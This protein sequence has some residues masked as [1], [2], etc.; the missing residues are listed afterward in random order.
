MCLNIFLA[1]AKLIRTKV[2]GL[3][4]P[5]AF[6]RCPKI[7]V[8]CHNK[9]GRI[10]EKTQA[11]IKDIQHDIFSNER[12]SMAQQKQ[13]M[14]KFL[15]NI[16]DQTGGEL[17]SIIIFDLKNGLPLYFG[18]YKNPKQQYNLIGNNDIGDALQDFDNLKKVQKAL[19]SFGEIT[20]FGFLE[21]SIFKLNQGQLI[22]Y[23]KELPDTNGAICFLA[24]NDITLGRLI[25]L[26]KT[27]IEQIINYVQNK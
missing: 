19:D 4:F 17:Q 24:E 27:N 14:N 13:N 16:V 26:G 20:N 25:I 6:P 9:K 22:V 2:V 3:S 10:S 5:I 7:S 23:F 11:I 21:Y 15:A 1:V 18:N 8:Y 12:K